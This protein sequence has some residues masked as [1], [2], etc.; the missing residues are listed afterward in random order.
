MGVE[1]ILLFATVVIL[2][3]FIEVLKPS[4][5]S[6]GNLEPAISKNSEY[7]IVVCIKSST[8]F[9]LENMTLFLG[10]I[11][12]RSFTCDVIKI[13]TF[14]MTFVILAIITSNIVYNKL[15]QIH[16]QNLYIC[17]VYFRNINDVIK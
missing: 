13:S 5:K 2:A 8:K 16:F 9:H 6:I 4:T 12:H 10:G 3:Y 15:I 7:T 11:V 14:T 1:K 17:I